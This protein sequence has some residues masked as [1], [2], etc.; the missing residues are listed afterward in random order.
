MFRSKQSASDEPVISSSLDSGKASILRKQPDSSGSSSPSSPRSWAKGGDDY[1]GQTA[2]SSATMNTSANRVM[3]RENSQSSFGSGKASIRMS[4]DVLASQ[5]NLSE[6]A[7]EVVDLQANQTGHNQYDYNKT[8]PE[9]PVA[10]ESTQDVT[11]E[12]MTAVLAAAVQMSTNPTKNLSSLSMGHASIV[13]S[14]VPPADAKPSPGISVRTSRLFS[15]SGKRTESS[16]ALIESMSTPTS[17]SS[18][19]SPDSSSATTPSRFTLFSRRSGSTVPTT[20]ENKTNEN[21]DENGMK[22]LEYRGITVK[23]VR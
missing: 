8:L 19:T 9:A 14:T 15:F 13:P 18:G 2:N 21:E 1:F 6:E 12:S 5:V 3:Q 22:E 11:V 7:F 20:N 23:E 17:A 10:A 16:P 4:S